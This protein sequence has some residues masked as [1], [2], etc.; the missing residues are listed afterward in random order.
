MNA[1]MYV[2]FEANSNVVRASRI[3][4]GGTLSLAA[5][6]YDLTHLLAGRFVVCYIMSLHRNLLALLSTSVCFVTTVLLIS[7]RITGGIFLLQGR[8]GISPLRLHI[9]QSF[10]STAVCRPVFRHS[11]CVNVSLPAVE[12][13]MRN[14]WMLCFRN[15]CLT[16]A[17][18]SYGLVTSVGKLQQC[19]DL[20]PD[21]IFSC[22]ITSTT[23][24]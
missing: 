6:A 24:W 19:E 2:Q 21:F 9:G 3:A 16:Y 5:A 1:A 18:M 17:V 22:I 20:C 10:A 7:A 4:V 8:G 13:G 14:W 12:S 23:C 11:L 15:C